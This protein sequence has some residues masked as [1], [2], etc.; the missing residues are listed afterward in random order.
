MDMEKL[1]SDLPKN[2]RCR[3]HHLIPKPKPIPLIKCSA[4]V[5]NHATKKRILAYV[6]GFGNLL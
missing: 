6:Y 4:S 1:N 3:S 2:C 5:T